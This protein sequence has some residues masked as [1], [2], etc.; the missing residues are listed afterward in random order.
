M[1]AHSGRREEVL[2]HARQVV[3]RDGLD[4]TSLRRIA[5]EGGFTTGVLSHYFTDKRELI[6][7]CFEWTLH[8]W[9]DRVERELGETADPE[10]HLCRFVSFAVPH[11]PEQHGEWRLWLNFCVTAVGD[12]ELADLLVEVDRRWEANATSALALWQNAGLV[13][14]PV[15]VEQQALILSRLGDGLG[16]RALLTGD[17]SEARRSYVAVLSTLGLSDEVAARA[18]QAPPAPGDD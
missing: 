8:S 9:L 5:R 11:F 7:A 13:R 3:M 18:L 10:E 16:L 12:R 6:A 15:P 1:E 14:S 4:A 2:R 17:W